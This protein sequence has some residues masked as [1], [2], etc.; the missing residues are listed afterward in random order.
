[1]RLRLRRSAH[2]RVITVVISCPRLRPAPLSHVTATREPALA[3][4]TYLTDPSISGGGVVASM[5][6]TVLGARYLAERDRKADERTLRDRRHERLLIAFKPVLHA[7]YYLH[8]AMR[9][10]YA[11]GTPG[12]RGVRVLQ[13][14]EMARRSVEEAQVALD[15]EPAIGSRI[16]DPFGRVYRAFIDVQLMLD[17]RKS[18]IGGPP[19]QEFPTMQD[20]SQ[21]EA[22]LS[23]AI[24]GLR[25]AMQAALRPLDAAI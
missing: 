12:P 15:L 18:A 9:N 20:V 13:Q 23:N 2:I 7:A 11:T 1:M 25:E 16:R 6:T 5:V 17:E 21:R 10:A 24:E 19:G 14:L 8:E 3:T 4:T 22:E